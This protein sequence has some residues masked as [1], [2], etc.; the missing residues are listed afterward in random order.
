MFGSRTLSDTE[1]RY[2]QIEKE[3]LALVYA[4]EKF[5][6][7][8]LGKHFVLRTDH[9]PLLSLLATK[10]IA[11]LSPR[12]QRFR[13]RLSGFHYDMEYVSGQHFHIPDT[14]SRAPQQH[15]VGEGHDVLEVKEVLLTPVAPHRL[16]VIRRAQD[17]DVTCQ[18][19]RRYV[20]RGWP[21]DDPGLP[22]FF[23]VRGD[24]AVF[25]GLLVK[26]TRVYVP[27]SQRQ[28]ILRRLH[29]GHFGTTKCR[30]RASETVWWPRISSEIK[31][32]IDEC[33][34]CVQ[35]RANRAEP[36]MPTEV[37][38]RPWA[39]VGIDLCEV[40]GKHYMVVMDYF[41]KYIELIYLPET[42]ACT[43]IG[44]LKNIFARHG[45]PDQV[46]TDNGPQFRDRFQQFAQ[47]FG[48]SHV[49]SSPRYPQS[50]GQAERGVAIASMLLKKNADPNI[51]LLIYRSTP[52]EC[53][54]SPAELL[55]GRRIRTNLPQLESLLKPS[56]IT[57]STISKMQGLKNRQK[58]N[59]DKHHGARPLRPLADG[60]TVWV[61]D[62][63]EYGVIAGK[64]PQPRSYLVRTQRGEFR[65]NRSFLIPARPSGSPIDVQLPDDEPTP[66]AD[67]NPVRPPTPAASGDQHGSPVRSP[68]SP[69]SGRSPSPSPQPAPTTTR[70]GRVVRPPSR[71]DL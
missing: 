60:Q 51:G 58:A 48:F 25:D 10:P 39:T 62:R 52:L 65:R 4:C 42:T 43:V 45:I 17:A 18:E 23:A 47:E 35:H 6:N 33:N 21:K 13:M 38:K 7:F 44:K 54:K 66:R 30:E 36:L 37:P 9:R 11:S 19:V 14:L 46:R 34:T 57:P 1:R 32:Y 22:D 2:A 5:R 61:T 20:L 40:R 70:S 64:A 24:L 12:I 29:E 27:S 63:Q 55:F 69:A 15:L 56:W 71:L 50:N 68:T 41:S 53:G 31:R 67:D 49:T 26:G 59:F 16:E 3:S 28:D 8:L